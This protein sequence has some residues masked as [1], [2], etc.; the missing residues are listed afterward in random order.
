MFASH[1][2]G[3]AAEAEIKVL[4]DRGVNLHSI[5]IV[6][7]NL[8]VFSGGEQALQVLPSL[9]DV[10]PEARLNLVIPIPLYAFYILTGDIS[11]A[12]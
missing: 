11:L 2:P 5:D 3:K 10:I 4:A 8:V 6:R 7:H 1:S 9:V 12:S